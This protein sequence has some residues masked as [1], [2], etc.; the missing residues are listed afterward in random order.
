MDVYVSAA[1][2][3][4][5]GQ[6]GMA[7]AEEISFTESEA[8]E[9]TLD[10]R[11]TGY[12]KKHAVELTAKDVIFDKK[13]MS[14]KPFALNGY[15]QLMTYAQINSEYRDLEPTHFILEIRDES[16]LYEQLWRVAL[17]RD[18]YRE[19]YNQALKRMV[20]VTLTANMPVERFPSSTDLSAIGETAEYE[21]LQEKCEQPS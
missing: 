7:M 4:E 17:D 16:V 13:G 12:M 5:I 18:E 9:Q 3:F 6:N 8:E 11:L 10:E 14:D 2:Y 20:H 1:E 21:L 19:L 15:A